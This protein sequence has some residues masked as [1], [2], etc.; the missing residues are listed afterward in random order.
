MS[1][2]H[3]PKEDDNIGN[4]GSDGWGTI[5]IRKNGDIDAKVDSDF[6]QEG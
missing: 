2:Q 4:D 1:T 6:S 5:E 3:S